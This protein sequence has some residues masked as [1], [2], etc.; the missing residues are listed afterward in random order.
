MYSKHNERKSVVAERLIRALKNKS[1][2]Y[3]TLVN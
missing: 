2:Q 1:C 3:M